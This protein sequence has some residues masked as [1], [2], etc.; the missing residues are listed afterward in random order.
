MQPPQQQQ[1]VRL[2][3]SVQHAH[4]W[5]QRCMVRAGQQ[6]QGP[7]QARGP[8]WAGPPL[9]TAWEVW[10]QPLRP[11]VLLAACGR[12]LLLG[13]PQQQA[14]QGE[15][16][17]CSRAA[18]HMV[19]AWHVRAPQGC[20]V[21]AAARCCPST[22]LRSTYAG[23]GPLVTAPAHPCC[24]S[25]LTRSASQCA[26]QQEEAAAAATG[27]QQQQRPRQR[28]GAAALLQRAPRW[29][30]QQRRQLRCS[31]C[32]LTFPLVVGVLLLR[33]SPR[34]SGLS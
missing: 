33:V 27:R 5:A 19:A 25:P 22:C 1:A 32:C 30:Q 13:P 15:R 9:L 7:Q 8:C 6:Q 14:L 4:P 34:W 31:L 3:T 21:P 23:R 18:A 26:S 12:R 24:A 28:Q 2:A 29:A 11:V 16:Q 20:W 17:G 10:E